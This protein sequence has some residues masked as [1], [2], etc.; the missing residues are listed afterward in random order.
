MAAKNLGMG[1]QKIKARRNIDL[2]KVFEID[3]VSRRR[4]NEKVS[5]QWK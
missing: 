2:D 5:D 4:K 3:W 1:D